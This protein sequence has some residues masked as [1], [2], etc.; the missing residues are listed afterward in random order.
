LDRVNLSAGRYNWI[1]LKVEAGCDTVDSYITIN[2]AQ[3]SLWIPSSNQTGLK[4]V[5]GFIVPA[6]GT[7][8][9]TIDFDLRRSVHKPEGLSQGQGGG[10]PDNYRLRPALRLVDNT[11]VGSITGTVD[12]SLINDPLC[13]TGNVVYI[14]EGEGVIPDDVDGQDPEPL[15]SAQ[16]EYDPDTGEHE[17]RA[18]FLSPGSYTMAFTC[19]AGD[20]DPDSSDNID[21]K[22]TTEV[23][24]SAGQV[25]TH[26]F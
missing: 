22:G 2:N 12:P 8:D 15:T 5:E 18:A 7:A 19:Q 26:N 23:T 20:D 11:E 25:T 4:L 17:Y 14:F 9:F 16:V 21:F 10:C 24:V 3:H 6:G 13:T 1:R